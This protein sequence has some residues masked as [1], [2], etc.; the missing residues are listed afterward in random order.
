VDHLD[1]GGFGTVGA[2][3]ISDVQAG[4][5]V[6]AGLDFAGTDTITVQAGAAGTHLSTSMNSLMA[7]GVDAVAASAGQTALNLD[8]GGQ[9]GLNA[10]DA[11][12][13]PTFITDGFSDA[14]LD[15]TLNV[16]ASDLVG[17][18]LSTLAGAL[19]TAGVD[20]LDIGGAGSI[21]S[22]TI[23]DVQASALVAA[24]LDFAQPDNISM[25]AAGT[26]L[27]T[28]LESLQKLGV[29]SV[30]AAA[31]ETQLVIGL[32]AN[33]VHASDLPQFDVA[34]SD[35]ALNVVL[36]IGD[37]DIAQTSYIGQLMGIDLLSGIAQPELYG[38]LVSALQAAGIDQVLIDATNSVSIEDGLMAS[39]A[40]AGM[41]EALPATELVLDATQSGNA[42]A[43]TLADMSNLGVDLV[44]LANLGSNTPVYIDLGIE[45]GAIT[46]AKLTE[47]L[48]LL[49]GDSNPATGIFSGSSNVGLVVDQ[50]TAEVIAN[51]T[52]AL[53]KLVELGFTELDVVDATPSFL[54]ALETAPIEVKLIGSDLDPF[55]HNPVF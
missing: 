6:A 11:G 17:A 19:A 24:G 43:T 47:L 39:L 26:H 23:S 8:L 34:Q 20:H 13:L 29:D 35:A 14:S 18:D 1:I 37:A 9:G 31:G 33:G 3:T 22:A 44:K 45:N 32:G 50:A 7:L 55:L 42:V 40:N 27:S 46:E 30:V 48:S 49:D 51:T 53:L 12:N 25:T 4:A 16:N 10:L 54:L 2:A 5:L 41:L 52:G 15:V 28:S 21:E 36:E 38:E